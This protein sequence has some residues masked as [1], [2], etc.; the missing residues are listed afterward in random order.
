MVEALTAIVEGGPPLVL[1]LVLI[2]AIVF[3][4]EA[5][6]ASAGEVAMDAE[7]AVEEAGVETTD[8]MTEECTEDTIKAATW[9]PTM[10]MN[11]RLLPK[12]PIT[13]VP[14]HM[15]AIIRVTGNMKVR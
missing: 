10:S 8:L 11:L 9:T 5:V 2:E 1:V 3:R 7:E 6:V 12:I 14:V 13:R 4:R 15:Q